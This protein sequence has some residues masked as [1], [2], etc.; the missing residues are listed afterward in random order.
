MHV[1]FEVSVAIQVEIVRTELK[2][3]AAVTREVYFLI[4]YQSGEAWSTQEQGMTV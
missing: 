1:E 3:G 2:T 4:Y